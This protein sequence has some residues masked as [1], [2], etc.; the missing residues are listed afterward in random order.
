MLGLTESTL[1]APV[2]QVRNVGEHVINPV[3][4]QSCPWRIGR[5]LYRPVAVWRGL[6]CTPQSR[7]GELLVVAPLCLGLIV[8]SI[9]PN[10]SLEEN[11]EFGVRR[12]VL[13]DLEQRLEHVCGRDV[14]TGATKVN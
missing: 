6:S 9:K 13:R 11:V 12:R 1:S 7:I 14:R 8:N 4:G 2:V 3:I 10:D 5:R